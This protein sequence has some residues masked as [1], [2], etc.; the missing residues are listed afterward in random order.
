[1]GE[2]KNAFFGDDGFFFADWLPV[3]VGEH[4]FV[5]TKSKYVKEVSNETLNLLRKANPNIEI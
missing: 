4:A 3:E 5:I 2:Q 1:M